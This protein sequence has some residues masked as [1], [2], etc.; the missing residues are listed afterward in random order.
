MPCDAVGCFPQCVSDSFPD[1]FLRWNLICSL[2]YSHTIDYLFL[3]VSSFQHILELAGSSFL[4]KAV[5]YTDLNGTYYPWKSELQDVLS[6]DYTT[7]ASSVC[8]LTIESLY[9]GD[10]IISKDARCFNIVFVPVNNSNEQ[11]GTTQSGIV[12]V[13]ITGVQANINIEL[14]SINA[15]LIN[16]SI[17]YNILV[18][19]YNQLNKTL[20]IYVMDIEIYRE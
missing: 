2:P 14:V 15:S 10:P 11:V 17:F 4:V 7:L 16:E 20:N 12:N 6:T 19:G 3:P 5:I 1:F 9:L 13:N 18:N 8:N